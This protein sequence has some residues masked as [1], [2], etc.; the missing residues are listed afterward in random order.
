MV[1][2]LMAELIHLPGAAAV[3]H[4]IDVPEGIDIIEFS[5]PAPAAVPGAGLSA[6][7]LAAYLCITFGLAIVLYAAAPSSAAST[8]GVNPAP[9]A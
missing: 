3:P 7:F 9:G 6:G 4:P 2:P 8:T 5:M 1:L